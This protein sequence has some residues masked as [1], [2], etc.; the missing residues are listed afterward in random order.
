MKLSKGIIIQARTQSQRFP[1]KI[2]IPFDNGNC[3]LEVILKRFIDAFPELPLVVATSLNP[4]DDRIESIAREFPSVKIFRG[5]EMNVLKRFIDAAELNN[6]DMI[7]RVCSDNVFIDMNL[8]RT[9]IRM[10]DDKGLD[11]I[12]YKLEGDVPVIKSHQGLY[13]ELVSLNALKRISS[14]TTEKL[15]EEH[16]T[17]YIYT[18]PEM[19]RMQ[20]ISAPD[21]LYNLHDI[22]LTIDTDTDF[23]NTKY[24]YSKLIGRKAEFTYQN[25]IEIVL[26]NVSLLNSMREQIKINSK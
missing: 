21:F 23:E 6:L 2:I 18:H 17:N 3:I 26:S 8:S 16:V 10:A 4:H 19:F 7:L 12:S 14:L 24:V 5:E 25:V 13:T 1:N 22:R 20:L 9:L 11:Y 15:Y